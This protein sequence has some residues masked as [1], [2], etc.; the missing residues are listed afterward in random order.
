M[1][2]SAQFEGLLDSFT[3]MFSLPLAV[4]GALA[5]LLLAQQYLSIFVMIGMIMLMGLVAKNGIL[6]VDFTNSAN[7]GAPA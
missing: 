4:I 2:L 3:I 5:G 6:L 7:R 1:V